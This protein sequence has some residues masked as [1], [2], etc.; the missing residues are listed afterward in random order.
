MFSLRN[1]KKLSLNPRQ[2]PLLSGALLSIKKCS[3]T[4]L[5]HKSN[6]KYE[7]LEVYKEG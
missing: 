7:L 5:G 1:K 2:C 6:S 4:M 3:V